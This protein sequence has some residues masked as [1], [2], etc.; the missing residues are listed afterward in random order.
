MGRLLNKLHLKAAF[1]KLS[2][3]ALLFICIKPA[4][5]QE[6]NDSVVFIYDTVTVIEYIYDTITYYDTV[7]IYDTIVY[8]DTILEP[9]NQKF[10][11]KISDDI[12]FSSGIFVNPSY[13]FNSFNSDNNDLNSFITSTKNNQKELLSFGAGV[14]FGIHY[15]KWSINSGLGFTKYNYLPDYNTTNFEF[16]DTSYL[17]IQ[18]NSYWQII[19][20][21]SFYQV[22]DT[23]IVWYYINDSVYINDID[24]ILIEET[25]TN[26][27]LDNYNLKN[28][29]TYIQIPI[30]LNYEFYESDKIKLDVSGGLI[31]GILINSKGKTILSNNQNNIISM[32]NEPLIQ[33]HFEFLFGLGIS[34]KINKNLWIKTNIYGR[35]SI[36]SLYEKSYNIN[37]STFSIGLKTGIYWTF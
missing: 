7:I 28:S 36:N 9:E 32:N 30:T 29:Y 35:K 2:F 16:T 31:T 12:F 17:Q 21:D 37:N 27:I 4:N 8:F 11:I 19:H 34:N 25:D 24:S 15:K 3:L 5:A 18:N 13:T 33:T 10:N 22:I 23:L 26:T 1:I 14:D 20:V 6:S